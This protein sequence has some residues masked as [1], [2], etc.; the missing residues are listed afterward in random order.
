MLRARLFLMLK[1]F[2]MG[3]A[4]IIPGVSGGTVAFITGVYDELLKAVASVNRDF[5]K[6]LLSFKFKEALEIIH[7]RFLLTIGTGI[8]SAVLIGSRVVHYAMD[9]FPV[10]TW[11]LFFGFISV[12]IFYVAREIDHLGDA[13]HLS[14]VVLGTG[15]AY[16][17]V[18]L[19]PVAT[20]HTTL[21]V[22]ASGAIAICAMILP[23][24]SGSFLL[25]ILGKYSFVTGLL[26]NPFADD[27]LYWIAIFGL[28]CVT[29]LLGFSKLLS[30]MLE[31][32]RS[33][34]MAF[35]T[36][37]MIG[38]L[39]KVWPWKEVVESQ[40]VN[41]KLKVIRDQLIVPNFEIT[42]TYLA[43]VLMMLAAL[44][45]FYLERISMKGTSES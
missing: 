36:G 9:V 22:F 40:V 4:D 44:S 13:K 15:I 16:A 30:Y 6:A 29:G 14:L 8:M 39:K 34:T 37:F 20:P 25:L 45:V 11:S 27:H 5:F 19:I 33:L 12:S 23:G 2:C 1:G 18:G 10:Y 31:Y 28:G 17:V 3:V 7:F 35:L 38:S 21:L 43:I 32:F 24:I 41:G 26:K 42:E